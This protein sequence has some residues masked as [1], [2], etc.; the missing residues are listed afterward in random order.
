MSQKTDYL[1][2]RV[3]PEFKKSLKELAEQ[4]Q[5]SMTKLIELLV[6]TE[7]KKTNIPVK[8]SEVIF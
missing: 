2:L 5:V 8:V 1:N 6:S 3:A 7:L 4:R